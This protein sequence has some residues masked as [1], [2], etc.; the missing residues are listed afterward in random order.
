MNNHSQPIKICNIRTDGGTQPRA[1]IDIAVVAEYADDMA[2]GDVFPPVRVVYDGSDYWLVDGFHRVQAAKKC[3]R[4]TIDSQITQG[5]VEDAR[6]L[7][8]AAN[9]R[10]GKRRTRADKQRAIKR[11]LMG[12]AVEKSDSEI[13]RHVGCS[14]KTVG[15]Y[16]KELESSSEIPKIE[17]R[18]VTRNGVEYT[19][20]TSNI[21]GSQGGGG[22]GGVDAQQSAPAPMPM[23]DAWGGGE[24]RE[25]GSGGDDSKP[26]VTHNSGNNEWYTPQKFIDS[27]RMVMGDID[28]DPASSDIANKTVGA[29]MFFTKNDNGLEQDWRGR[30][31]MNPPYAKSLI[32][33][34]AEKLKSEVEAGNVEQAVV[35]VNNGTE[36]KWFCDMAS[37]ASGICFPSSRVSFLRP[38]GTTGSPLQGQAILYVG[39]NLD[40]FVREFSH[41]GI[42]VEVLR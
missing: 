23:E 37:V 25:S 13:A 10:H 18:T 8:L 3:S 40:G 12:W 35:L 14:D 7:S 41:H 22:G 11:A 39:P 4:Q 31:W 21:G 5:T 24:P 36:T 30:V 29:G 15:K 16:R 17:N 1:E 9:A 32:G 6:W 38:D 27:A 2:R 20:S 42:V 33:L 26:H 28:L 34:F 19:Q